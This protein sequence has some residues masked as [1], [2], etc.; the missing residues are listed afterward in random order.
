MITPLSPH[1]SPLALLYCLQ[2]AAAAIYVNTDL[3]DL[4]VSS[5]SGSGLPTSTDINGSVALPTSTA[6]YE[7][8]LL[9]QEC[10]VAVIYMAITGHCYGD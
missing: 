7:N 8:V 9:Q 2:A 10:R 5:Q 4:Q 1:A 3:V 6:S